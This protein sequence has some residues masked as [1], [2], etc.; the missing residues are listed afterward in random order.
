ME[1]R[2]DGVVLLGFALCLKVFWHATPVP[3]VEIH[4]YLR[5]NPIDVSSEK[6]LVYRILKLNAL[7]LFPPAGPWRISSI[8]GDNIESTR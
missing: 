8:S 6:K 3:L 7:L 2:I 5:D 1:N 4:Y